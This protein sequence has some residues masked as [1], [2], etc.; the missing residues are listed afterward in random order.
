MALDSPFIVATSMNSVPLPPD[1]GYPSRLVAPGL[2]G[3][4]HVKWLSQINM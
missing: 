4:R 2:V 1:H 3:A